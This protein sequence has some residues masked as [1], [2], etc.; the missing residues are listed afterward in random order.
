MNT[1]LGPCAGMFRHRPGLRFI[2]NF[3]EPPLSWA[4]AR[5][6]MIDQ[7]DL[8]DLVNNLSIDEGLAP[9]FDPFPI[10]RSDFSAVENSTESYQL[11][12]GTFLGFYSLVTSFRSGNLP[13]AEGSSDAVANMQVAC[14]ARTVTQW[15]LVSDKLLLETLKMEELPLLRSAD[16]KSYWVATFDEEPKESFWQTSIGYCLTYIAGVEHAKQTR[17]IADAA[18]G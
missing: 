8:V 9:A 2:E 3:V 11:P 18:K 17:R 4:K 7:T 1:K 5:P 13:E 6:P 10:D 14:K 16:R 12:D 15:W